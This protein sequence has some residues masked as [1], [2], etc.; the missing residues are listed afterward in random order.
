MNE[1]IWKWKNTHEIETIY[2]NL[3]KYIWVKKNKHELKKIYM[4]QTKFIQT[5]KSNLSFVK[6]TF[7]NSIEHD[8]VMYYNSYKMNESK[9]ISE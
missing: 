7:L 1:Y 3:E 2:M 4:N 6:K 5:S 8:F 9:M